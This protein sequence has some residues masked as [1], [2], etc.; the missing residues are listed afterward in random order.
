ME[1]VGLR[2]SGCW[3][4]RRVLIA[5]LGDSRVFVARCVDAGEVVDDRNHLLVRF[6]RGFEGGLLLSFERLES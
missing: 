5:L 3:V 2:L 6:E 4:L 1:E